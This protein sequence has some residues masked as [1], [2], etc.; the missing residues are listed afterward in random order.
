MIGDLDPGSST[1]DIIRLGSVS[2]TM[3]EA[4]ALLPDRPCPFWVVADEQTGGKGRHGRQWSS[5]PGNLYAT[6]AL[7]R[8][9]E[10][11][12]GAELGFVAGVALHRAVEAVTGLNYPELALKWPNDL[13]ISGAKCAGLLLEGLQMRGAFC[14]LIG[15]GVNLASAPDDTPYPARALVSGTGAGTISRD[16]V[17]AR[18]ASCWLEE[19]SRWRAGFAGTRVAWLGRAAFLGERVTIRLPAGHAG[20]TMRGIDEHGRLLLDSGEGPRMIDAGDLFFGH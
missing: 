6:L 2:S 5:P 3:D 15:F 17:L 11:A 14:V 20:G 12:R 9:C 13:L 19:L 7:T 16:A 10:P 1:G 18:L 8:P 4:R